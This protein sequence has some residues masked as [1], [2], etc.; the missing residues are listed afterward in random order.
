MLRFSMAGLTAVALIALS[1]TNA[2]AGSVHGDLS[3]AE[4]RAERVRLYEHELDLRDQN[5]A[6]F[7]HKFPVLGKVLASEEGYDEFLSDHTREKLLCKH[8]PFLCAS[9]TATSS[10]TK[11]IPS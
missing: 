9:S 6:A 5:P 7:D 1:N 2:I 10:I 3:K 4:V 11:L 8:T